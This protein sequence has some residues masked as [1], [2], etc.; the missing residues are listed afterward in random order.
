MINP[1]KKSFSSEDV[2]L[3]KFLK[4]VKLFEN[5][6]YEELHAFLPYLYLRMYRVDEAVFFRN[7]PSNALYLIKTGRVTLSIDINE[8][9]EE[10]TVLN[11]G[12]HFGDNTLLENT[13]RIYN[14]M[15]VSETAELYVIPH[16]NIISI[17]DHNPTIKAKMLES[18]SSLYNTYTMNLFKAYKSSF[19]FFNL[20]EAYLNKDIY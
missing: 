9:M 10:L 7:D 13:R 12:D 5:L 14:A 17:F 20:G 3:F 18:L 8:R 6:T 4:G 16:V 1:F 19:G 11:T 15:V 2:T